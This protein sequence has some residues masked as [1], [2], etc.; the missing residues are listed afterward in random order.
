MRDNWRS[1][2]YKYKVVKIEPLGVAP[3]KAK[4]RVVQREKRAVGIG[5]LFLGFLGAA[6]STMGAASMTLTVQARQLLYGTGQTIIVWYSA[7]AEQFA[8]GY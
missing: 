7:A 5:A 3:T 8:E 6:G 1:E 4:R 2:L